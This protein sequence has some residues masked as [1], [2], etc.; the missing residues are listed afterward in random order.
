MTKTVHVPSADEHS[1]TW[2]LHAEAHMAHIQF[3]LSFFWRG[4]NCIVWLDAQTDLHMKYP[5]SIFYFAHG[6][7][8]G[9]PISPL[10]LRQ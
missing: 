7:E 2:V 9:C 6:G 5:H 1:I 8:K 4:K 10:L 3:L